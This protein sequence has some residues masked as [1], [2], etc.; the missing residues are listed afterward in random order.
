MFLATVEEKDIKKIKYR[1]VPNSL[2]TKNF[3]GPIFEDN[4]LFPPRH[5]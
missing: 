5:P 4:K 1:I 3:L 2:K